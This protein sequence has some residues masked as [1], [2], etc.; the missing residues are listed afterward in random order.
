MI[1]NK[2]LYEVKASM[3]I[4]EMNEWLISIVEF[5]VILFGYFILTSLYAFPLFLY[6]LSILVYQCT[7]LQNFDIM[8]CDIIGATAL[9]TFD[10]G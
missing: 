6:L 4:V 7:L 5:L 2:S 10:M 8:D 9:S 1:N 3:D